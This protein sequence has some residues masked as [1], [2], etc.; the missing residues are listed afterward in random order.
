[1]AGS[2]F[3]LGTTGGLGIIVLLAATSVAVIAFFA[4]DPRGENPWRRL[5]APALAVVALAGIA[6]LAVQ[7]YATLLG[8][9][10]GDPAAWALPGQLRRRRGGRAGLG[11]DPQDPPPGDLRHDRARPARHHRPAT[12]PPRETRVTTVRSG[13]ERGPR[14]PCRS[15]GPQ[16]PDRRPRSTTWRRRGG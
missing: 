10:P 14:W 8:V 12:P 15:G 7:H 11:T 9:P 2:F 3:G 1:M 6:V 5:A 13:P 4:R 16:R